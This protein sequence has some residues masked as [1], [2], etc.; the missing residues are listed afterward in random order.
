MAGTTPGHDESDR[1]RCEFDRL[2]IRWKDHL[3]QLDIVGIVH[4]QVLDARRLGPGAALLHQRLALAFHVGFDPALQN[5]DHLKV[6]VME[7]QF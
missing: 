2:K 5:I 3:Q 7:M 1:S 4:D 6:D